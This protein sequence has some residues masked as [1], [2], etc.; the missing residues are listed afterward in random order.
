MG[1]RSSWAFGKFLLKY[2]SRIS[3]ARAVEFKRNASAAKFHAQPFNDLKFPFAFWDNICKYTS[4]A[5]NL[6]IKSLT[7]KGVGNSL[8][9]QGICQGDRGSMPTCR[10]GQGGRWDREICEQGKGKAYLPQIVLPLHIVTSALLSSNSR[11]TGFL[12]NWPWCSV[13]SL[14]ISWHT[15]WV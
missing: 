2:T 1:I 7:V 11:M 5:L 6:S 15:Y 8:S 3:K 9:T 12:G 4:W 10:W 13:H 14:P